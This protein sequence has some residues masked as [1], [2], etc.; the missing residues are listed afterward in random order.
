MS[1]MIWGLLGDI[2]Y[3]IGIKELVRKNVLVEPIFN[4]I[5]INDEFTQRKIATCGLS[6]LDLS[7]YVKG[8]SA[9]SITKR[10]YILQ[11]TKNLCLSGKR[12]IM[13]TDFVNETGL[14]VRIKKIPIMKDIHVFTRDNYVE[15]LNKLGVRAIGV[16]SDM[17]G[18]ERE[19]V[20]NMLENGRI[21]GLI[22][23]K[24][25]SEGVNIPKVDSVILCNSTKST[26][27]FPQRVGRALRV[28]K[29][30]YSKKS[31]FVYEVLLNVPMEQKWSQDNF[32]E[33]RVEGYIKNRVNVG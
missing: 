16:S 8:M 31:A 30:D 23:G 21:D 9:S 15:E 4:T 29:N 26:I 20:F 19:N 18:S 22:F 28:V 3:K 17:S 2:V 24:L 11:I 13:Y 12:F 6:K 32:F 14:G 27:L 25:G 5:I 1:P 7:R 10:N 33:Y